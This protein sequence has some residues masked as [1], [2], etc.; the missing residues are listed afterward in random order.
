[1]ASL[2]VT[3]VAT[4]RQAKAADAED[5]PFVVTTHALCEGGSLVVS[6]VK[7]AATVA[8]CSTPA[9]EELDDALKLELARRGGEWSRDVVD[10]VSVGCLS[11]PPAELAFGAWLSARALDRRAPSRDLSRTALDSFEPSIARAVLLALEGT[12]FMTTTRVPHFMVVVTGAVDTSQAEE[13]AARHFG[14]GDERP[15]GERA[16]PWQTEQTT[17]RMTATQCDVTSPRARYA[18][19]TPEGVDE[20]VGIR[21]ALEVLGGGARARLPRLFSDTRIGKH[22]EAWTVHLPGGTLSGLYVEP[23]SHVSID[24]L[25]RFVDG[26][27]KQLRLVG[28]SRR[29]LARAKGRLLQGLYAEWQE[30]LALGRLLASYEMSRG[31]AARAPA[32][33]RALERVT[34]RD[35]SRAV[36][37]GL[38]DARRT[39]VEIYPPSFP[40]DD[41]RVARQRL[42]TIADGDTL[43]TI[44][45]RFQ[46]SVAAIARANDLDP[47]YAL[48]PG[49]PLWIP[50]P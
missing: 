26:A 17:E 5:E 40:T 36:L 38:V 15:R 46:V 14:A 21:V 19:L 24:R 45:D 34:A 27:L 3:F 42:Y 30:P 44:A 49:Q 12:T 16:A 18:W 22:A 6:P 29:E 1:M 32:D 10:G 9:S 20:E 7:G 23:S 11:L 2:I 39:T 33:V 37:R 13:L 47:K 35:V 8:V 50:P 25:R 28:P 41:P 4:G 43:S 48:T 31:G